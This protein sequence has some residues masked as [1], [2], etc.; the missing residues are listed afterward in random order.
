MGRIKPRKVVSKGAG[1]RIRTSGKT[2][3]KGTQIGKRLLRGAKIAATTI[4]PQGRALA[5]GGAIVG[6]VK[7][8]LAAR[9]ATK[10]QAQAMG[11][12]F[13]RRKGLVPKSVRKYVNKLTRRRKA[14]NKILN[15]LFS[16]SGVGKVFKARS[17]MTSEGIITRAEAR[18]A[19]KR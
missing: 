19:L 14:E 10:A 4:T 1:G 9:A 3:R 15:K 6:K 16:R 8:K 11:I 12:P 17:P 2:L 18:R 7:E 13:R 5:V